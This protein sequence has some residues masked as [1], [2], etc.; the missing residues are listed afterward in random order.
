VA[1]RVEWTVTLQSDGHGVEKNLRRN[2]FASG[3]GYERQ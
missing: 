1:G 2:C 3:I